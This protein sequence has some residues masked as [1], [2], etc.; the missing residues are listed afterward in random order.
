MKV[1]LV[2]DYSINEGVLQPYFDGLRAG[3]AI[4]SRCDHCKHVAFPARSTC[5]ICHADTVSFQPLSGRAEVVHRSDGPAASHALVRFDGA[6]TQTTVAL[7]N[8]QSTEPSGFL[9]K[10]PANQT[11]NKPPNKTNDETAHRPG[12]WLC[13]GTSPSTKE[14]YDV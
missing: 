9:C 1:R 11:V 3:K 7:S 8:P 10:P 4:A 14:S 6:D 13:L 2:L 12:L 5:A